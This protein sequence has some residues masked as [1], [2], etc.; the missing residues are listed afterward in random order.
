MNIY[1]VRIWGCRQN[2]RDVSACR[3]HMPDNT[4]VVIAPSRD[5]ANQVCYLVAIRDKLRQSNYQEIDS[6]AS[7]VACTLDTT[8]EPFIF[9]S[10]LVDDLTTDPLLPALGQPETQMSAGAFLFCRCI[11]IAC[12]SDRMGKIRGQFWVYAPDAVSANVVATE[13][14]GTVGLFDLDMD[15]I[16]VELN[17]CEKTCVFWDVK[18]TVYETGDNAGGGVD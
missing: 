14:G 5:V 1:S 16:R 3:S 18:M 13:H 11:E 8:E 6:F 17:P 12:V 9:E 7:S 4:A 15:T 2:E 10:D